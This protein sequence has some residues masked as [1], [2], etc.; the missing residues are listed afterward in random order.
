MALVGRF[1]LSPPYSTATGQSSS[2]QS[3]SDVKMELAL[4]LYNNPGR[5]RGSHPFFAASRPGVRSAG[6][7]RGRCGD[8]HALGGYGCALRRSTR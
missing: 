1:F 5:W 6:S 2:F 7:S 3:G 8:P 4:N